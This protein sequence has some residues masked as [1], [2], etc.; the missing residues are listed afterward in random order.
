MM[1]YLLKIVK[2]IVVSITVL[3]GLNLI[4][5]TMDIVLPINIVSIVMLS[6]LGFPGLAS[7]I[8]L[9]FLV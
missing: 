2:R 3:Y 7:F 1:K 9:Y 5:S 6:V 4:I 8:A